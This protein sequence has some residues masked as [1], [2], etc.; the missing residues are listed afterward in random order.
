M[1]DVMRTMSLNTICPVTLCHIHVG[2][3]V[4]TGKRAALT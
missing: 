4:D 2:I 3:D 1:S